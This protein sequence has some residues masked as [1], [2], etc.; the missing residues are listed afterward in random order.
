MH[1]TNRGVSAALAS[2][3]CQ[4]TTSTDELHAHQTHRV[5]V[6][7]GWIPLHLADTWQH[8]RALVAC[9]PGFRWQIILLTNIPIDNAQAAEHVCTQWRCCRHIEHTYR[10]D[11]EPGLD[12][13]DMRVQTVERMRHVFVLYYS[14][15]CLSTPSSRRGRTKS[16]FGCAAWVAS[17]A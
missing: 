6:S 13:E 7:L 10:F 5:T 8:I 2:N 15:P 12:V 9:N 1:I 3:I 4:I 17:S 11:Q 16:L 14:P